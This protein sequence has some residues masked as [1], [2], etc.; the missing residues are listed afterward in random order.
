VFVVEKDGYQP[1]VVRQ[2][3]ARGEVRVV[4]ALLQR[5][6]EAAAPSSA[7]STPPP[8]TTVEP[9]KARVP[10]AKPIKPVKPATPA[11]AKPPSDIRLE[12]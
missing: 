9:L 11:T 2:G 12:R 5:A 4:A 3:S 6:P 7:T 1:Y 8:A 10:V